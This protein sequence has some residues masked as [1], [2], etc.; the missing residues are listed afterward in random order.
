MAPPNMSSPAAAPVGTVA[1]APLPSDQTCRDLSAYRNAIRPAP[2][3]ATLASAGT[4]ASVCGDAPEGPS[5]RTTWVAPLLTTQTS[6]GGPAD[7]GVGVA[8]ELTAGEGEGCELERWP[9]PQ[10]ARSTA[11]RTVRLGELWR[12][13]ARRGRMTGL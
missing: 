9:P 12:G 2:S 13:V 10:D 6:S 8:V 7:S 11:I 3:P 5:T 4:V 1:A